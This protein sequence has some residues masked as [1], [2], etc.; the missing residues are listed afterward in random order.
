M[1]NSHWHSNEKMSLKWTKPIG[2]R[3]KGTCY[4]QAVY[5]NAERRYN[6]ACGVYGTCL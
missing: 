4:G 6:S 2:T 3:P 5:R 1:H